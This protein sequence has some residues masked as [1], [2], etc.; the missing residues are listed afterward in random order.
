MPDTSHRYL[1]VGA[2]LAAASAVEG[3]RELDAGGSILLIGAET[4]LPYH[5]PHLSKKLWFG[6]KKLEEIYVHDRAWYES[7]GAELALGTMV[8]GLD[9]AA[10]TVT[11]SAGVMYRFEK[12]LLATG[13]I[14]RTLGI[15]GA[16]LEGV[17]YFRSLDDYL[18][19]RKEA[20]EGKTALVIGGGF[21]GSEMAAALASNR[22]AV[23]MLFPA[24]HICSRVFPEGLAR[25]L[26]DRYRR[27]GV[28]IIAGASAAEVTRRGSI[29]VTRT[30]AG[31]KIESDLVIAGIGIAPEMALARQAGLAVSDGVEVDEQLRTSHPDI[32]AAGDNALAPCRMLGTRMRMEHWDNALAQGKHAG[33]NM[34]GAAQPF[35]Y[36]PYF[37]SDL[38]EFGY[39]AVG[40]VSTRLETFADW[41]KEYDTGVVYYLSGGRVRGAMMCNVWDKVGAARA[42]IAAGK[43]FPPGGLAGAII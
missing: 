15:P 13:G 20:A 37:F 35:T 24:P 38:F 39:E 4:H 1:I 42:L 8:T 22:V 33:R 7:A 36:L 3:I 11:T 43:V 6:K 27:E 26:E 32:W 23:T 30:S 10:K 21:I 25:A 5:R 2:G 17:R 16:Q 14:P 41:R 12:L 18:A 19:T 34:A 31:E 40:E 9:A 28:R 29:F